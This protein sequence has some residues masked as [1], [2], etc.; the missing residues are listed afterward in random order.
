MKHKLSANSLIYSALESPTTTNDY[1]PLLCLHST[2]PTRSHP[3]GQVVDASKFIFP[4]ES[5]RSGLHLPGPALE[6]SKVTL[7]CRAY[8]SRLNPSGWADELFKSCLSCQADPVRLYRPVRL[9]NF[10]NS[11][12]PPSLPGQSSSA[13]SGS[14]ISENSPFL[15]SLSGHATSA[16]LGRSPL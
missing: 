4:A 7:S 10:V 11:P 2:E 15:S 8:P 9:L 14:L 1:S 13:R 16:R 6:C 12:S 3:A 5:T